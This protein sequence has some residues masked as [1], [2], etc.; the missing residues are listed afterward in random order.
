MN[1]RPELCSAWAWWYYVYGI[2]TAAVSNSLRTLRPM[3]PVGQVAYL[4]P[5]RLS[6]IDYILY[7]IH[8]SLQFPMGQLDTASGAIQISSLATW[9]AVNVSSAVQLALVNVPFA[10]Y[11]LP[12]CRLSEYPRSY[13]TIS[14]MNFGMTYAPLNDAHSLH[15][16][17]FLLANDSCFQEST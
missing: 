15:D 7:V 10:S 11:Q 8:N 1:T 3:V 5:Y 17:S 16:V 6:I 14:F 9:S 13:L 12:P 4:V 2:Q